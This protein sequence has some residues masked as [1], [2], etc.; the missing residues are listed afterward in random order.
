MLLLIYLHDKRVN[1]SVLRRHSSNSNHTA[2][3]AQ[4]QQHSSNTSRRLTKTGFFLLV[5]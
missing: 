2:A 1:Y 4:Q 5:A 3:T